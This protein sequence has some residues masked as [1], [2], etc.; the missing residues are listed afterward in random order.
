MNY[1]SR[2]GFELR[3]AISHTTRVELNITLYKIDHLNS[4]KEVNF[5][6]NSIELVKRVNYLT[7]TW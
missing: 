7:I 1:S 3:E 5:N 6:Y 2:S 4:C